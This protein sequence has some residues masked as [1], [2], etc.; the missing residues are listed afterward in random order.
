MSPFPWNEIAVDGRGNAYVNNIGFAFPGGEP[1]A[2]IVGLVDADG[3]YRQVADD[4][5][6]PNGM[7]I[8][9]DGSTLIVAESYGNRLTAFTIDPDGDLSDRRIWADLG[10]AAPDGI[11]LDADGAVWYADVPHR[12][13]VRVVE[14]G[15]VRQR[16]D[17]DRGCFSVA[18]GGPQ[19]RTLFLVA[20]E[21][22]DPPEAGRGPS[23]QVLAVE[24][25]VGGPSCHP[26]RPGVRISHIGLA[27]R[28]CPTQ[29]L[30]TMSTAPSSSSWR[31]ACSPGCSSRTG[32]VAPTPG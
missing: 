24:V 18:L 26:L 10:D 25:D 9:P 20:A 1:A 30:L 6:F 7:A 14:G 5:W 12:C 22:G 21:W 19:G 8:T 27:C 29:N 2:G 32:T 3:T 17:L 15:E 23:G 28:P 31:P 16:F 4:V 11:C 13:C